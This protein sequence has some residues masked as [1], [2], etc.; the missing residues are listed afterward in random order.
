MVLWHKGGD[1]YQPRS[2]AAALLLGCSG[3]AGGLVQET[4]LRSGRSWKG[5]AGHPTGWLRSSAS[6]ERGSYLLLS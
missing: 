3:T 6:T 5:K 1:A 2:A 4:S